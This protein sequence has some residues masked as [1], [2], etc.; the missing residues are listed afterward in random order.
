MEIIWDRQF[1]FL[2]E[3]LVAPISPLSII[4]G[5]ALGGAAVVTVQGL[6]VFVIAL[7]FGFRP[8]HLT[9]LPGRC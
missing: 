3:M 6:V 1:G 7:F 4:L 5:R 2:K 9:R 8:T